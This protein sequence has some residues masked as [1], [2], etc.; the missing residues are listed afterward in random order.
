MNKEQ[1]KQRTKDFALRVMTLVKASRVS[2]LLAEANELTAIMFTAR[3]TTQRK[4]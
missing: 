1:L 4:P 3:R 2:A